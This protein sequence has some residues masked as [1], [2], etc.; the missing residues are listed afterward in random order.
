MRKLFSAI[1]LVCLLAFLSIGWEHGSG[2]KPVEELI[3]ITL[4][5][6]ATV[7]LTSS[8]CV[9]AIRVNNDDDVI[10]YTLPN[11]ETGLSILI[12]SMYAQVVTIDCYD[13][14]ES[15]VLDGTTLTAGNAID[16]PGT[17]GDYVNLVAI[18]ATQ[19]VVIGRSGT[20]VDGGA[21]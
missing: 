6:D 3:N 2:W 9:N 1:I 21:D 4:D 13:T 20:W 17:A 11:A 15:I 7:T 18:S 19:W 10:D 14:N 5:T 12:Q 8:D 16:S